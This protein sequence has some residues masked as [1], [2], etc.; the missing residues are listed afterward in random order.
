MLK[1]AIAFSEASDLLAAAMQDKRYLGF[2]YGVNAAFSVELYLKCL[3]T[4]EGSEEVPF[5]HNLKE[6]FQLL[7]EESKGKLR[8][9]HN[10]WVLED[11]MMIE[12]RRHGRK[13]DLNSLLE[14]MQDIFV[15]F[16][17]FYEGLPDVTRDCGFGLRIFADCL[18]N[19]ILDLR[20][21]WI[22][23]ESTSPDR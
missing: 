17:Y 12:V 4:V 15:R 23:D 5:T 11:S 19:R 2:A 6:L 16:R 22:A 21:D 7:R 14:E 8:E 10:D 18:R 1:A 13:T 9:S 20:P 3:L